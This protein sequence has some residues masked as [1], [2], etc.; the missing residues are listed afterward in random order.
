MK[1]KLQEKYMQRIELLKNEVLSYIEGTMKPGFFYGFESPYPV[2]YAL[3]QF[4]RY[5]YLE[6]YYRRTYPNGAE[7]F[8]AFK[9]DILA[10]RYIGDYYETLYALFAG[11]A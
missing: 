3:S 9:A 7:R 6:K 4:Q 2:N 5:Q 10:V 8:E 11:E 1:A